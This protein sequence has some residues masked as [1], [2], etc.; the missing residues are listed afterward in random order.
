M[1][2]RHNQ[3]AIQ[4]RRF[5]ALKALSLDPKANYGDL[6]RRFG[7][8]YTT[9]QRWHRRMLRDGEDAALFARLGRPRQERGARTLAALMGRPAT[10][11]GAAERLAYWV[12]TWRECVSLTDQAR[13][14]WLRERR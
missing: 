7:V 10:G 11:A 3:H 8:A 4:Q 12:E 5:L 13:A 9:I 14:D 1:A 2:A 6:A